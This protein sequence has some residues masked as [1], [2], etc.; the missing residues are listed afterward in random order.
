[1][2]PNVGEDI[3][4]VATPIHWCRGIQNGA[5]TGKKTIRQFLIELKIHLHYVLPTKPLDINIYPT[6]VEHVKYMK[7]YVYKN[8]LVQKGL[9]KFY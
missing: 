6:E 4:V 7:T 8:G 2:T 5:N 9:W 3:G 1:M